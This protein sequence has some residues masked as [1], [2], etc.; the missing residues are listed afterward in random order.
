MIG[1]LL[2]NQSNREVSI[3]NSFELILGNDDENEEVTMS[4]SSETRE[5]TLNTEFFENRK[6][7][8]SLD[9]LGGLAK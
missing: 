6:E 4:E 3:V 7:Q 5:I 1:A 9:G 8:C 2:G